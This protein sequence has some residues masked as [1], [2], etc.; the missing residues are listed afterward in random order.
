MTAAELAKQA[1]L[2]T[3]PFIK[4][5]SDE[6]QHSLELAFVARWVDQQDE[7][8]DPAKVLATAREAMAE[9]RRVYEK[10]HG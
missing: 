4:A 3:A 1:A 2:S 5:V 6:V 10:N 8:I 7:S 9:L